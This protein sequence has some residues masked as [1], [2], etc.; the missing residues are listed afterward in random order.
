[1]RT[2]V[3]VKEHSFEVDRFESERE[4][5]RAFSSAIGCDLVLYEQSARAVLKVP[6]P[7]DTAINSPRVLAWVRKAAGYV[8]WD[9]EL[10]CAILDAAT[11]DPIWPGPAGIVQ[12]A[13]FLLALACTS[14]SGLHPNRIGGGDGSL[15]YGIY[16]IRMPPGCGH[17]PADVLLLPRTASYVAIDL[18]RQSLEAYPVAQL[19]DFHWFPESDPPSERDLCIAAERA[20][21]TRM[22][23]KEAA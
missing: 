3:A 21:L 5:A 23:L 18:V 17:L 15:G 13:A 14:G 10:A 16:A 2:L 4:R 20:Y 8:E 19:E 9:H 6:E 1:M 22:L 7:A 11:D 12:T